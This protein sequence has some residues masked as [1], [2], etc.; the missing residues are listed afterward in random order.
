MQ[1]L[2]PGDVE[3]T[4]VAIRDGKTARD[5]KTRKR[6]RSRVRGGE[7]TARMAIRLLRAAINWAIGEGLVASNPC[8]HVRIGTDGTRD[9]ILED[10]VDYRRLFETLDRMEQQRR[11]RSSVAD[12]IRMIALTGAVRARSLASTELMLT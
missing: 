11:L 3:R 2:T 7:G 4:F 1:S 10:I 8:T 5:T 12:A 6:G 9:V